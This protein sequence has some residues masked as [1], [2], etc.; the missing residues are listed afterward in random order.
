[1]AG[2]LRFNKQAA[3]NMVMDR[4]AQGIDTALNEITGEAVDRAPVRKV[5]RKNKGEPVKAFMDRQAENQ[6]SARQRQKIVKFLNAHKPEHIPAITGLTTSVIGL[7]R[8]KNLS[9]VLGTKRQLSTGTNR[10]YAGEFTIRYTTGSGHEVPPDQVQSR[11]GRLRT[12]AKKG[13]YL[14]SHI[15]RTPVE[16]DG[17]R[18]SGKVKS[19]APYSAYVE[20]IKRGRGAPQPFFRPAIAKWVNHWR[21]SFKG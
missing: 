12:A 10:G 8:E 13:G 19:G 14:K 6:L 5:S 2:T 15:V 4:L 16:I 21:E 17:L 3:M 11:Q 1:M 9:Y 18:V 7:R 20:G